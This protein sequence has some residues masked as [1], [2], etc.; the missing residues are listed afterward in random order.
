MA[1]FKCLNKI[2]FVLKKIIFSRFSPRSV[3]RCLKTGQLSL[4][5]ENFF[6]DFILYFKKMCRSALGK[7]GFN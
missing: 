5:I 2:F 3:R 6:K 7:K 1:S 4:V